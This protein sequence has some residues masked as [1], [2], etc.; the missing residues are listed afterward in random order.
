MQDVLILGGG[1]VGAGV[2][3]DAAMRGLRVALLDKHPVG[4]GTSSRSSRLIHGGIRYLELGDFALVREALRERATLLRIAPHL[5]RHTPFLF[6]LDRGNWWQWLRIGVGVMLY[7]VL[8]GRHALGPHHPLTR[9]RLLA[10]EPLLAGAPLLGGAIYQDARGDD[11]GLVRSNIAAARAAGATVMEEVYADIEI[12][13]DGVRAILP[14][15]AVIEARTLVLALGPWTD[16]VRHTIGLPDRDL[17]GGTK[18]VHLEFSLARLP[19][20]HALALRHP[21]DARVMFCVPEPERGLVLVGTT[22][23]D[24]EESPDA[25]TVG[26]DDVDYLLRAVQHLFPA[27]TLGHADIVDQWVGVRPLLQQQGTASSRSREHGM[28][29]EGNV[30]TI[31]GGKLTTYRDMAEEAVDLLGTMLGRELPACRTA[32]ERLP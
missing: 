31:A 17:V 7:K 28:V 16:E 11:I 24:T 13:A 22:D 10:R 21:D 4:W 18:G 19:L 27:L 5:V 14:S 25:L 12:D 20:A 29:Q 32:E 8:A 26:Q 6:V 15:G 30:L 9:A 1:I 23:T 3:R 2:A